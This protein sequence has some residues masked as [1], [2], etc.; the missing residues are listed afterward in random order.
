M[1]FRDLVEMNGVMS[2][3]CMEAFEKEMRGM[4]M[5]KSLQRNIEAAVKN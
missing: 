4:H 5:D 3:K 1:G 2:D